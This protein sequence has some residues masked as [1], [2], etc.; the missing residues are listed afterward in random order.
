MKK[1]EELKTLMGGRKAIKN[2]FNTW[3]NTTNIS[4]SPLTRRVQKKPTFSLRFLPKDLKLLL[5]I[6]GLFI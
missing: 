5:L 1:K 6:Y 3:N 4:S 2:Q